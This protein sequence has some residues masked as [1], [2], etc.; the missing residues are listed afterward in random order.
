ML[1]D[2]LESKVEF[3]S[4]DTDYY[5]N[6]ISSKEASGEEFMDIDDFSIPFIRDI[7]CINCGIKSEVDL[8][9]YVY[10][11]N[12]FEK[13]NGMGPDTVYDFDSESNYECPKCYKKM[14]I[15]GWIRE[16]PIGCYDSES[17]KV[18]IIDD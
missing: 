15:Y 18:E 1:S 8:G 10:D 13:E 5:W 4:L 14:R 17:L 7:E 3:K 9:D 2:L 6:I 16:Y 11:N 12:S